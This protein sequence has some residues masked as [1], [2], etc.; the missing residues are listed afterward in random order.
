MYLVTGTAGFIGHFVAQKLIEQG[1]E[2][3]GLDNINEYYDQGLKFGRLEASGF[4]PKEAKQFGEVIT[5][6]TQPKLK[7][8]RANLEDKE[9]ME[10]IFENFDFKVVIH[11]AAQAGVRYSLENP[12]AYIDSNITGTLN[13]LEGCRHQKVS[14]LVFA[15]SSSVYGLNEKAPF[16][17]KDPVDH[18]VSLYASTKRSNELMAHNYAHLFDLPITGLRFFTVYGPWGRPDMALFKFTK[19]IVNDE[20]IEVYNNG[21]MSRDFTYVDDV[22][23]GVVRIA[24]VPPKKASADRP[25]TSSAPFKLYNI[26]RSEPVGL[27]EF[28]ESLEEAI[29]KKAN[30]KMMPMQ[31]GDVEKTYAD[32]EELF[33]VTDFRP[34]VGIDQGVKAFVD[35]YKSY[36]R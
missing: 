3:L 16:Q 30:K 28:I 5:S 24:K 35:W 20:E 11:L 29:G 6:K 13:I 32:V 1:E 27:L 8:I 31:P 36:F 23:E 12:H 19:G 15:S 26:G 17:T 18:P 7:F 21:K 34:Q 9:Q 33:Q 22:V 4:D 14:H 2:V 10:K 25:D